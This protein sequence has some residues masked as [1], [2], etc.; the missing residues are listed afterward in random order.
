MFGTFEP[1]L[2]F[3]SLSNLSSAPS[4]SNFVSL[5]EPGSVMMLELFS[6]SD[7]GENAAQNLS[8]PFPEVDDLWVRFLFRNGTNDDES[9]TSYPLFGRGLFETDMSWKDFSEQIRDMSITDVATWCT[10]CDAVN[11][12]CQAVENNIS[13]NSSTSVPYVSLTSGNHDSLAPAIAGVIGAAVTL[14]L[15]MMIA[16]AL[17]SVG[18]RIDR[19]EKQNPAVRRGDLGVLKRSGSGGFKGAEKLASD[20]DLTLKG[21]AGAT[22]IRHER[23]GSWEL[24]HSPVSPIAHSSL[25]KEIEAARTDYDRRSEDGI[26]NVNPFGDPVK[27]KDHI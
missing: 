2:S 25:D 15:F 6:Y 26:G 24:N 7:A 5:P 3:F 27:P 9:I 16:L 22:V 8:T 10:A 1:M 14:A 17:I 23:V 4:S 19:R 11:L 21:G 13:N 18:Y 12:F 20:T